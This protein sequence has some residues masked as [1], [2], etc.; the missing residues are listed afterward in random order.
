MKKIFLLIISILPFT[1]CTKDN[2]TY[3]ELKGNPSTGFEWTCIDENNL[4]D[5]TYEIKATTKNKTLSGSPV[6]YKFKLIG[7]KNGTTTIKCTYKRSWE[8][9][10][11]DE[12]KEYEV[13]VDN[14]LKVMI[15]GNSN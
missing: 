14:N 5:I 7:K 2:N 12:V 10:A 4:V 9:N 6:I 3:L 11:G 15:K 13:E 1:G 8:E